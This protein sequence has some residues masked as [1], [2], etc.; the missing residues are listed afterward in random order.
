MSYF[1]QTSRTRALSDQIDQCND[2]LNFLTQSNDIHFVNV[3]SVNGA[4]SGSGGTRGNREGRKRRAKKG[5]PSSRSDSYPMDAT[6]SHPAPSIHGMIDMSQLFSKND[7]LPSATSKKPFIMKSTSFN[8]PTLPVGRRLTMNIMSTWGDPYYVGLTGI[9][10]FDALGHPITL[11]DPAT[12]ITAYPAS[13]NV[14]PEY[15]NDPRTITN[16]VSGVNR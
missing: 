4:V 7:I 16:L 14:L 15:S 12:Q 6:G 2:N 10:L 13:I 8:I 11:Q 1:D 5:L 9:E 3:T